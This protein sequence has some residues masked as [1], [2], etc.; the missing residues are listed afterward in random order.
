MLNGANVFLSFESWDW[1]AK[2]AKA[3]Y[4]NFLQNLPY[5]IIVTDVCDRYLTVNFKIDDHK[6]IISSLIKPASFLFLFPCDTGQ[7]IMVNRRFHRCIG[8]MGINLC[9]IQLFMP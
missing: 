2:A 3:Q 1:F 7:R 6:M 5:V 8:D 4:K 9:G